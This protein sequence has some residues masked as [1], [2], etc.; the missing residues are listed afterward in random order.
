MVKLNAVA[1][2][3]EKVSQLYKALSDPTRLRILV[4]LSQGEYNV[5]SI[6][7]ELGLEQSAVSHQLKIL[8]TANLVST[9]KEGKGVHYS[10]AD[11]HVLDILGQSFNHVK[12]IN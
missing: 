9:R 5:S 6:V 12:H 1:K 8:R 10:V 4:F 7:K 11:Q 2:D 3:I